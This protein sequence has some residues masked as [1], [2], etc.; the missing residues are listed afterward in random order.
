MA[1][2]V[3][4][5]R[6]AVPCTCVA[7]GLPLPH[8]H[9]R[10]PAAK[11]ALDDLAPPGKLRWFEA[12]LLSPAAWD[13][14]LRDCTALIHTAAVVTLSP[15]HPE[16]TVRPAVLGVANVLGAVNRCRTIKRVVLTSS[17]AAVGG[18]PTPGRVY[19]GAEEVG[20]RAQLAAPCRAGRCREE[21]SA[22]VR[23]PTLSIASARRRG[24]LQPGV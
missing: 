22:P 24:G 2:V 20:V 7:T 16:R 8:P 1:A 17:I 4:A 10:S 15:K 13:A 5:A 23:A 19:T 11:A 14:P 18:K 12:D 6:R 21:G 9:T 3:P